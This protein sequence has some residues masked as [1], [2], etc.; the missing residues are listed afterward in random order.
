MHGIYWDGS[1]NFHEITARV[2]WY[3]LCFLGKGVRMCPRPACVQSLYKYRVKFRRCIKWIQTG[4]TS[5]NPI[6]IM[7]KQPIITPLVIRRMSFIPQ[8]IVYHLANN[9]K[10]KLLNPKL[11]ITVH[12]G[13]KYW[14]L[15][16]QNERI[17]VFIICEL[18]PIT[19][20]PAWF[21]ESGICTLT[22]NVWKCL[23]EEICC[24]GDG[25]LA[26]NGSTCKL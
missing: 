21:V 10:N 6:H 24:W 26:M 1:K 22:S 16:M 8:L 9:Y 4:D 15:W 23:W 17:E 18:F 7:P 14:H 5:V 2:L 20:V 3:T 13:G 25:K 11:E 19:I 12:L